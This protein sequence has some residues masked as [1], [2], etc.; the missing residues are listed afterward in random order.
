MSVKQR[1]L[2]LLDK[3]YQRNVEKVWN[4]RLKTSWHPYADKF[5]VK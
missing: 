2:H 3:V 1:Y 5:Q 4:D